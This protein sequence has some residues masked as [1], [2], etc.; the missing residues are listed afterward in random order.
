MGRKKQVCIAALI[1]TF[2]NH[3]PLSLGGPARTQVFLTTAL[4]WTHTGC[5]A[6]PPPFPG[7]HLAG[8]NSAYTHTPRQHPTSAHVRRGIRSVCALLFVS[9]AQGPPSSLLQLICEQGVCSCTHPR[10]PRPFLSSIRFSAELLFGQKG[11]PAY[12]PP[13]RSLPIASCLHDPNQ[14]PDGSFE[15][16]LLPLVPWHPFGPPACRVISG[17]VKST[18]FPAT[19]CWTPLPPQL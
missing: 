15:K 10:F 7:T 2:C 18:P 8:Q 1:Y 6:S 5:P 19:L 3:E 11:F 4:D 14:L 12:S 9:A 13:Q 16:P 17:E